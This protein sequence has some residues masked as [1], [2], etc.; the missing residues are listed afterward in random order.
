MHDKLAR[1]G[2][3]LHLDEGLVLVR[4][5]DAVLGV[6]LVDAHLVGA[7]L[8]HEGEAVVGGELDGV[9]VRTFLPPL[10]D[11]RPLV[12]DDTARV[13]QRAITLDRKHADAA[14]GEVC[15]QHVPAGLVHD[16]MTRIGAVARLHVEEG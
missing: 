14:A 9:R 3:G 1:A 6:K 2:A 5:E 7:K 16:Q 10:V 13:L 4:R 8:R 12:L 11:A 15:D